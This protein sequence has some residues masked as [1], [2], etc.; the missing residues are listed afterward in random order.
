MKV[1]F[2]DMTVYQVAQICKRAHCEGCPLFDRPLLCNVVR[3]A[4]GAGHNGSLEEEVDLPDEEVEE[5]A[6]VH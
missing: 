2:G 5:D 3:D 4:C 6:D 1:K